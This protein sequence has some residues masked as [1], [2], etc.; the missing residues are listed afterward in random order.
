MID[1]A[2]AVTALLTLSTLSALLYLAIASVRSREFSVPAA[3]PGIFCVVLSDFSRVVEGGA[4]LPALTVAIAWFA[5]LAAVFV[6]MVALLRGFRVLT[7]GPSFILASLPA[8]IA[9][10]GVG[11][12]MQRN[13]ANDL[14][15]V[16]FVAG[17]AVFVRLLGTS[18]AA[19]APGSP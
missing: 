9:V 7:G 19:K 12:G 5:L 6:A 8:A 2:S 16:S 18:R 1:T 15:L 13:G 11:F 14:V 3:Y 17:V 10:I 4:L